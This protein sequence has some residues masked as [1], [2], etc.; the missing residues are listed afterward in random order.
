MDNIAKLGLRQDCSLTFLIELSQFP[1]V[2][3]GAE[4]Q[5]QHQMN[6][7]IA[8]FLVRIW[9]DDG[10]IH[11]ASYWA[12]P[13]APADYVKLLCKLKSSANL[14]L[15]FN[16]PYITKPNDTKSKK[17]NI[18]PYCPFGIKRQELAL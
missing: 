12:S 1:Q 5:L 9:Q 11:R 17:Q 16:L 13:V 2:I 7:V 3:F 14:A 10:Q 4:T 18:N 6:G 15:L 8:R